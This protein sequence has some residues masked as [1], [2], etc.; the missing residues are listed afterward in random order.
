MS[1]GNEIGRRWLRWLPW[2]LW[3][4]TFVVVVSL[5]LAGFMHSIS[6]DIYEAAGQ[7]WTR[8]SAL[9]E[10]SAVEGFQYFPQA[11]MFFA[12]FSALGSPW[13]GI[14][15]RALSWALL[16]TGTLRLTAL[17]APGRGA[18]AFLV[19][20]CLAIGPAIGPLGNGQANLILAAL[21]LHVAA[22][23]A[24]QHWWRASLLLVFGTAVK[25]H[26]AIVLLL[27]WALYRPTT[28]RLPILA[29]LAFVL[30]WVFS[31]HAYVVTQY[32]DWLAKLHVGAR[33][34]PRFEDLRG[35]LATAGWVMPHRTAMIVR[36]LAGLATLAI[37]WV[38]CRRTREPYRVALVVA[39]AAVYLMLFNPRTQ[40][41]TYAIPAAIVAV[42]AATH[43][44]DGRRRD[45]A[46]LMAIEVAFT[47][48]YNYL[49]PIQLWLKPLAAA[50]LG[51][52]L[53]HQSLVPPETWAARTVSGKAVP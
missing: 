26:F 35:M 53:V 15:W 21:G 50:G 48:N 40:S 11:A 45:F 30:P 3:T 7:D 22:D 47:L 6:Y 43:L 51:A 8:R 20:T 23:V 33:P 34:A 36:V 12:L 4:V 16:A 44:F 17:M 37:C 38:A 10:T 2:L 13:G 39:F 24:E 31:D 42:M 25:P 9:Y 19:A 52:F 46:I 18:P 41:T 28:W 1:T 27:V 49:P 5:G 14:L 32:S 29:F